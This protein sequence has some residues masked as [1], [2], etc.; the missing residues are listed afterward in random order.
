VDFPAPGLPQKRTISIAL[1]F[2]NGFW[3]ANHGFS[4]GNGMLVYMLLKIPDLL[5][6]VELTLSS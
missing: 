5:A 6:F 3:P 4:V 2:S 1:V